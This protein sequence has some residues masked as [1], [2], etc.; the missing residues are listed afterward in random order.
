MST[1]AGI[2]CPGDCDQL[3]NQGAMVTLTATPTPPSTFTGWSGNCAGT[4]PTCTVTMDA[5]KT[6]TATFNNAVP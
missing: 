2:N 5:A 6:A 1:P 3:Y 4:S